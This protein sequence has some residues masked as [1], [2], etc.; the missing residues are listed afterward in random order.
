[1]Q[2]LRKLL[3]IID[4]PCFRQ[5]KEYGFAGFDVLICSSGIYLMMDIH[6]KNLNS[7]LHF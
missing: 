2:Y 3:Q 1:M 4:S 6:M 7:K 5:K